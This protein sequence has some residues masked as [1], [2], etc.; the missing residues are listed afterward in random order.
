MSLTP[1]VAESVF[2]R[3]ERLAVKSWGDSGTAYLFASCLKK[4]SG[5]SPSS[6]I[7]A[8]NER[9]PDMLHSIPPFNNPPVP[10]EGGVVA[11]GGAVVA[12]GGAERS[13]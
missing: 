6:R 3:R 1:P 12:G 8:N 4:T 2:K 9:R 13:Y 7:W 5:A 11:T 10:A